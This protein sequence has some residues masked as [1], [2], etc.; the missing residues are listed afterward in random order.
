MILYVFVV[1]SGSDPCVEDEEEPEAEAGSPD[2]EPGTELD[3]GLLCLQCLCAMSGVY[4]DG[5]TNYMF[6]V[7]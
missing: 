7:P 3:E 4:M 6:Y 5:Y 1:F 2:I